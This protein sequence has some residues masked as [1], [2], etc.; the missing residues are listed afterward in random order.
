M[1]ESQNSVSAPARWQVATAFTAV[2]L[3]WGSTYLGI[4][5]AVETIPP[6][7]M[8][9]ARAFTAGVVLY[10]WARSRGAAKP[11]SVHWQAAAI[12]G[13]LLLLGGNGL[14]S[15]AEQRVPSG[16]SALIIGN[17]LNGQLRNTALASPMA[18]RDVS[19]CAMTCI[20]LR[21]T[22]LFV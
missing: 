21:P 15:W 7:S 13:G 18:G 17:G 3:I 10:A 20:S 4:R 1:R 22:L 19:A 11:E 2:Y 16:V 5:F 6:F 12:V 8:A 9:G 14:V